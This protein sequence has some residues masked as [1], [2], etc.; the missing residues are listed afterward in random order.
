MKMNKILVTPSYAKRLL[1]KNTNNRRVNEATLNRYFRDMID[2]KWKED[3]GEC[4][5]ISKSG[6]I[7]DGQH[8]LLAVIKANKNIN[9]HVIENL[10]DEIFD[11]LDTGRVRNSTDTFKIKGIKNETIIPSCINKY[12]AYTKNKRKLDSRTESLTNSDILDIYQKDE[13]FWQNVAKKSM[14]WYNQFA[15]ILSPSQ[16]GGTY[17]Y[18]CD[19]STK[20]ADRFMTQLATGNNIENPSINLL[21]NKLMSDKL[22]INKMPQDTKFAI[23]IKAWNFFRKNESPKLL[24][25]DSANENFPKAI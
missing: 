24:K 9:L 22:S 20:D 8:R 11:V 18:F 2:G 5:K 16:I 25:W 23:V 14:V 13:A 1:E 12:T 4:I 21:R 17:A 15:K 10:D 3:T 6:K 19:I 7:L